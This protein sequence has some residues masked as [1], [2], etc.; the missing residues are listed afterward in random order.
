LDE[1]NHVWVADG[2]DS[3]DFG[4]V[5]VKFSAEWLWGRVGKWG[6]SVTAFLDRLVLSGNGK[7]EKGSRHL[8]AVHIACDYL[9]PDGI[10]YNEL[11][12]GL[13]PRKA[14]KCI[15]G[16][17]SAGQTCYVGK[18]TSPVSLTVYDKGKEIVQSE[19]MW[20]LDLWGIDRSES[21]KVVRVEAKFSRAF[22]RT[23]L[24]DP[25]VLDSGACLGTLWKIA[26]RK[27][28][29]RVPTD[30]ASNRWL[31]HSLWQLILSDMVGNYGT[32]SDLQWK[33]SPSTRWDDLTYL[34]RRVLPALGGWGKR[35]GVGENLEDVLR[36]ILQLFADDER[37]A[38]SLRFHGLELAPCPF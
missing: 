10:D 26:L 17:V 19:K 15:Q 32:R 21:K 34:E 33:S 22:W 2:A 29:W 18:R 24:D 13:V 8:S 28:Q 3:R 20:C 38:E 5:F 30:Q 9:V 27:Y 37:A 31:V 7:E 36:D 6:S 25:A 12:S 16:T 4:N 23:G 14:Y 11:H 1:G 35:R